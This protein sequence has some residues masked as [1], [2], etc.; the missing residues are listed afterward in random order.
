MYGEAYIVD[1][2]VMPT[3]SQ[4]KPVMGDCILNDDRVVLL[5][6]GPP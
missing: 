3:S 2:T 6:K 4:V 5:K 1:K